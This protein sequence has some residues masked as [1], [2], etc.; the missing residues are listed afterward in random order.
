MKAFVT[1]GSGFI[2]QHLVKKLVAR[3]DTVHALARSEESANFLRQLGAVVFMGDITDAAS[4]RPAMEGCDVV[5]HVA[6]WY[7]VGASDSSQAESINVGGTRRVLRQAH[8][9]GI[10]KIVYTSTIAVFGDTQGQLV[11]ETYYKEGPFLTE[12]DRTK[13]LAHYKVAM[14]LIE[15]GAPII[16][17]MP[18]A[19]YGPGDSS[20][21]AQTMRLFYRGLPALPGSDLTLT[22]AH[23]D[24]I[25]EG[26]LLAAAKGTVGE[27]YILTGPAIPLNEMVD[28]WAH[29]IGRKPPSFRLAGR[30]LRKFAPVVGAVGSVLPLPELFSEEAVGSLGATYMARSDKARAELGWT[31]RPLQT[32]LLETFDWIARTEPQ[33]TSAPERKWAGYALLAAAVLFLL[34][35]L[36]RKKQ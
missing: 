23:V 34:W 36:G 9:L 13:W 3:G 22:Y 24:D 18:G 11:D 35:Y 30:P 1:G 16:I 31:T 26:H 19:V 12:Y 33:E 32:G 29:L 15:K 2:G 4:L 10:P 27:S 25:A 6:A 20:I 5:F 21:V 17:V 14:P 7:K 28:F 8:E